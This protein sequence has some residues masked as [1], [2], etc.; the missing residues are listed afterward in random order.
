[1]RIW[2][3]NL[4]ML[5]VMASG[6][7]IWACGGP[8]QPAASPTSPPIPTAVTMATSTPDP[9]SQASAA[10]QGGAIPGAA[11]FDLDHV[12]HSVWLVA[13][14][15]ERHAWESQLPQEWRADS[16]SQVEL[17][18]CIEDGRE[19]IRDCAYEPNGHVSYYRRTANIRLVVAQTGQE[20]FAGSVA[21]SALSVTG[22]PLVWAFP[23][24]TSMEERY[25]DPP[26]LSQ[27]LAQIEPY[28]ASSPPRTLHSDSWVTSLAFSP[29][30]TTLAM[31]SEPS[32]IA[33]W[34]LATEQ[35][36]RSFEDQQFP[37]SV[38]AFS[39]DGATLASGSDYG[40]ILLWEVASGRPIRTLQ[41]VGSGLMVRSL[42]FSPDGR[43]LASP[44]GPDTPIRL[45]EASTGQVA[46][47]LGPTFAGQLAFS[48][49]GGYLAGADM[50]GVYLWDLASGAGSPI[51]VDMRSD[52]LTTVLDW[53]VGFLAQRG[54]LA[55]ASCSHI[56]DA[57]DCTAGE[58]RLWDVVTRSLLV[59]LTGAGGAITGM[60]VSPGGRF[61]AGRYCAEEDSGRCRSNRVL[62]WD[63]D[64]REV[65]RTLEVPGRWVNG[66]AFSPDG[67]T[68]ATGN[69]E[70]VSLW[71]MS[72]LR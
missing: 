54:V 18:A 9:V 65:V 35:L 20:L 64:T 59:S 16:L 15:G 6:L 62:V 58:V 45:W 12:P 34:D 56:E 70:G 71:D 8:Q 48:P 60:A 33:L 66:L 25:G 10:C 38:L 4:S 68:L 67:N 19:L 17:V 63:T 22:C 61:L 1:M 13:S 30:G 44:A 14:S 3:A 31:A 11:A 28:I 47:E 43:L 42:T 23:A 36:V 41:D 37:W 50:F 39:P 2:A 27:G 72:W 55:S 49:D 51:E 7:V 5:A 69:E 29:D 53:P 46:T 21:G 40:G 32:S 24:G 26:D 57:F 52:P